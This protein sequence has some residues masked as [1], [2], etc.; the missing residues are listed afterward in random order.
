[1]SVTVPSG[2]PPL[3]SISC[4]STSDCV[5]VGGSSAS[6]G[7]ILH[8]SSVGGSFVSESMPSGVGEPTSVSC[9]LGTSTC[10]S[11]AFDISS[12]YDDYV[13]WSTDGGADWSS[14]KQIAVSDDA[15]VGLDG[16]RLRE[17]QHM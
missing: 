14:P 2:T 10:E 1:M 7:V 15:W 8:Q 17:L 6:S 11:S 3:V 13:I 9:V 5:A 16:D 12:G 4:A